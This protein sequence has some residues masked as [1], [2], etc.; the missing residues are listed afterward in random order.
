VRAGDRARAVRCLQAAGEI[1]TALRFGPV[2]STWRS[3]LALALPGAERERARELAAE[4]LTLARAA[5][6]LR[7]EGIAL[8]AAGVLTGDA[9]AALATL[10]QSVTVLEGSPARLE[11]ARSLVELG[12]ALRRANRRTEA[13]EPLGAVIELAVSCG[14]PRLAERARDELRAAGGRRR[15]DAS[16]GPLALTASERRVVELA[17]TGVSNVE[18]AERLYVSLKTVETH[19][20]RAYGKLG[21]AGAG[22]RGRLAELLARSE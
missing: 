7:A 12:A 1:Y 16:T 4:D 17:A 8:R 18:I 22:S 14:A 2:L 13:R 21:L 3:A 9:D 6:S 10:R 19:L 20:S 11:L 5:G 15:R